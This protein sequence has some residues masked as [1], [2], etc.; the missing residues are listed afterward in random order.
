[1]K[2]FAAIYRICP[3]DDRAGIGV[4]AES[5]RTPEVEQAGG[6]AVSRGVDR[7]SKTAG[8]RRVGGGRNVRWRVRQFVRHAVGGSTYRR[9]IGIDR[10]YRARHIRSTGV[11]P[12]GGL[13]HDR[14]QAFDF[15]S[16]ETAARTAP[17]AAR[18][19]G[20]AGACRIRPSAGRSPRDTARS[21]RAG[22]AHRR[23]PRCR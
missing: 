4:W 2:Q 16:S 13:P 10:M 11:D 20:A 5:V 7:S 17:S 12:T 6:A 8:R 23:C 19:S 21:A 3:I 18:T 14:R 9:K 22:S 1:M 15:T